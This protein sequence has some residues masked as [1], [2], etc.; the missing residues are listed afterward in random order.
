MHKELIAQFKAERKRLG[1]S[2]EGVAE[3]CGVSHSTVVSVELSN[4]EPKLSTFM[5]MCNAIGY[6]VM[7]A[8]IPQSIK[9]IEV[10]K[11]VIVEVEKKSVDYDNFEETYT[12]ES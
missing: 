1:V 10:V 11:E 5:E 3:K 2:Q 7:I 6:M 9:P 4:R 12:E 8:P